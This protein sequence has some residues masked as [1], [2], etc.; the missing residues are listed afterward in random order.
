MDRFLR[1][2]HNL[3]EMVKPILA[4]GELYMGAIVYSQNRRIESK[5]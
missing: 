4:F 1:L 2:G 3:T 5:L